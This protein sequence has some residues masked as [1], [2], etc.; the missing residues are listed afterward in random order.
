MRKNYKAFNKKSRQIKLLLIVFEN[1]N[2]IVNLQ[3]QLIINNK[4]FQKQTKII[5]KHRA[6]RAAIDVREQKINAKLIRII[7][8]LNAYKEE[9]FRNN[10]INKNVV[11]ILSF[12]L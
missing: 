9:D 4:L 2:T 12:A 11:T 3:T 7:Q 5:N 10:V 6:K 8:K 1:L